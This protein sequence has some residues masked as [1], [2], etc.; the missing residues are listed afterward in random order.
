MSVVSL[1]SSGG[2]IVGE[3]WHQKAGTPH[4]EV[5]ALNAAANA[6]T[7]STVYVT[8]EPCSHYGRTP[9]CA[10]ALI[11]AKVARVVVA[12][13]DPNPEVAGRGINRLREAGIVVDVGLQASQAEALNPGFLSR[14]RRQQPFVTLKMASSMD[15]KTALA[16]GKSQWITGPH[17]R[18]DVQ[19][20]RALSCAILSGSGTVLIDDPSLNVRPESLSKEVLALTGEVPRQPLRV[21]LDGR[22]QLHSALKLFSLPG[23][24]LV[25]NTS[26]N[27]DLDTGG[28]AQWQAPQVNGK[29]DLRAVLAH[30]ADLGINNLWVEAGARLGGVFLQQNLIDQLIL[31]QA[32]KLLGSSARNLFDLPEI[33]EMENAFDLNWDDVRIV[34]QDIKFTGRVVSPAKAE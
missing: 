11:N 3:G 18:S 14:M 10:D 19:V 20:H 25:V 4:A 22:N 27:P 29:I 7:G 15:G 28:A 34:G 8:L 31:Y 17:A 12:M 33:T 6:A 21:I 24:V 32:P 13:E 26:H 2:D 30:L 5:H 23:E 16:N 9:P 1:F